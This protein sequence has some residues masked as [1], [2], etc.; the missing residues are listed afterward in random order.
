MNGLKQILFIF[1]ISLSF[2][3]SGQ[4]SREKIIASFDTVIYYPDSTIKSAIHLKKGY[5]SGYTIEYGQTGKILVGKYK[6]G[7]P[8]GLWLYN[9]L[10]FLLYKKGKQ[11]GEFVPN[12][13][14]EGDRKRAQENFWNLYWKAVNAG[15][16]SK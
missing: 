7:K 14:F 15:K 11:K 16:T 3:G 5:Y 9:D 4:T 10:S 12:Y 2:I 8:D 13:D 1:G 6:K